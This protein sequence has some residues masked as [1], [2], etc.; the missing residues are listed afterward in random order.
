MIA[1]SRTQTPA[2]LAC[3]VVT[4]Q[5]KKVLDGD[6]IQVLNRT[7]LLQG[8]NHG[9]VGLRPKSCI[10]TSHWLAQ[11]DVQ[12]CTEYKKMSMDASVVHLALDR[13]EL[14]ELKV[15]VFTITADRAE[16]GPLVSDDRASIDV[17]ERGLHD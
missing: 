1:A 13:G 16:E 11:V 2:L 17:V 8:V 7:R 9:V 3:P 14:Q 12:S 5:P 15:R 4:R 10:S 6:A